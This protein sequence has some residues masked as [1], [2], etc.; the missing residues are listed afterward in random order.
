MEKRLSVAKSLANA[1]V[2]LTDIEK[3]ITHPGVD[4]VVIVTPT[5]THARLIEIAVQAGK[6]V[7]SEKPIAL[8]L[9]ET[10]RVVG[11][12][13]EKGSFSPD[14]VHAPVRSRLSRAK[15]KITAG[16]LGKLETFRALSR[17]TYPPSLKF[18]LMQWRLVSG[19][20][21]ARSWIWRGFSWAKSRRFK[22]GGR[23]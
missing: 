2:A 21:G 18:L 5:E 16:E 6:A 1:E 20:G 17:D 7:F 13:Q 19:H 10:S 3:A 4:A 11:L 8:D 12:V 23:C 9:T 15:A 14:W 22:L